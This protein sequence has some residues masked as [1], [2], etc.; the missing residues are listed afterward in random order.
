MRLDQKPESSKGLSHENTWG[1]CLPCI[2]NHKGRDPEVEA[3]LMCSRN[4]KE[5]SVAIAE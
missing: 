2:A 5:A 3:N 1:N 4:K